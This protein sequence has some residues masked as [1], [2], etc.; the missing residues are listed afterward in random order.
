M[1]RMARSMIYY[2]RLLGISEVIDAL[3]A[4]TVED[5]QQ[6]ARETF[7]PGKCAMVVLGPAEGASIREIKL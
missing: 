2:K 4:V 1:A 5:V 6:V 7:Q 3:D